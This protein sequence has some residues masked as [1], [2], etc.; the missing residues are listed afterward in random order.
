MVLD[1][2]FTSTAL[3]PA[4]P[5]QVQL[6]LTAVVVRRPDGALDALVVAS[7]MGAK[8]LALH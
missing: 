5:G 7:A 3:T 1:A 4:R 2:C 8:Y 6:V